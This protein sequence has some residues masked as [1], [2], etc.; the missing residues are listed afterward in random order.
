MKHE[1]DI[2]FQSRRWETEGDAAMWDFIQENDGA[3]TGLWWVVFAL[4]LGKT[5]VI[6]E[7]FNC[8]RPSADLTF[9][10]VM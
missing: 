4:L 6:R 10:F 1:I 2:G 7:S 9:R 3:K 8:D 5:V